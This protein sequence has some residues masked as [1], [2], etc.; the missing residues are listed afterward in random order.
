MVL[1][2]IY[3]YTCQNP[4]W[5]D[6]KCKIKFIHGPLGFYKGKLVTWGC[7]HLSEF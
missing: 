7:M 1:I 4:I 5:T 3:Y 2:L 6:H